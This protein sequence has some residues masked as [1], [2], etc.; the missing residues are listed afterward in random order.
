[1]HTCEKYSLTLCKVNFPNI[2][3]KLNEWDYSVIMNWNSA[4]RKNWLRN[5]SFSVWHYFCEDLPVA[6]E[7]KFRASRPRAGLDNSWTLTWRRSLSVKFS[8]VSQSE[9]TGTFKT[10]ALQETIPLEFQQVLLILLEIWRPSHCIINGCL[11]L[12]VIFKLSGKFR[13]TY[14]VI[15]RTY[16]IKFGCFCLR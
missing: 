7:K 10:H 14:Q 9:K 5:E 1:M 4:L 11:L 8:C 2:K 15:Y 6:L 13:V 16:F 3:R 12:Y